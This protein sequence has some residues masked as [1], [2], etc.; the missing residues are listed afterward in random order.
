METSDLTA[1]E[2]ILP[3]V[4]DLLLYQI[5]RVRVLLP[6]L[7]FMDTY[8]PVVSARCVSQRFPVSAQCAEHVIHLSC[9]HDVVCE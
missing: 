6:N 7:A 3:G 4:G 8:Y 2:E 9:F 5:N 1:I